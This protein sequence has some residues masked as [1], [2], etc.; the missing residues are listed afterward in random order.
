MQSAQNSSGICRKGFFY[1]FFVLG[2]DIYFILFGL[3][4]LISCF[5]LFG[6]VFSPSWRGNFCYTPVMV[7]RARSPA[8]PVPK[9]T[10]QAAGPDRWIDPSCMDGWEIDGLPW[11]AKTVTQRPT[12]LSWGNFR[13]SQSHKLFTWSSA[14][15]PHM[16]PD[17]QLT[18]NYDLSWWAQCM[19]ILDCCVS[20]TRCALI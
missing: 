6:W 1:F 5:L 14:L 15:Q 20:Y 12:G 16:F 19:E 2:L 7:T 10:W 13:L 8:L 18:G 4:F 11:L 3:V 17:V 9:L